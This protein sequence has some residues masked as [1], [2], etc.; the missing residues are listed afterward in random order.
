MG[1][2]RE[3]IVDVRS[4]GRVGGKVAEEEKVIYEYKDYMSVCE[5]KITGEGQYRR[6]R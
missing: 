4:W 5:H 3:A 2:R 6:R 1:D